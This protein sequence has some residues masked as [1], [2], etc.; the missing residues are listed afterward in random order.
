MWTVTG[1]EVYRR[2]AVQVLRTWAGMD[3][4]RYA[5]FPDAHIHTGHPLYQFL[6]AAEI[7]RATRPLADDTPGTYGGYDVVWSATDD[8]RLLTNFADPVVTTFLH[9]NTRWMNQ[10][11]FGLFGRLATAIYADD[12]AGYATGVE[13]FTV[14]SAYPG[15]DNGA[16]APQIPLLEVDD[17]DNPY[18]H[19]IVQVREMGRDQ[20]HGECNIDNFTGLA[21]ILEVQG[22]RVDPGAG[23]VSTRADAVSSY[24]F[25]GR[26]LL[27]G[28]NA[29][30][31]F[32]LGAWVPWADERGEGWDGTVSQAYRGRLFNPVNEL[33]YEYAPE[34][35]VDVATEAPWLARLS[36]RRDGPYF[37]NGTAVTNFWAPGDKNPEYWVA[38]PAELAGTAPPARPASADLPFARWGL[39][40]DDR[41]EIVDGVARAHVTPRGTTGVVTRVMHDGNGSN[42]LLVRADGAAT[43]EVLDKEPASPR[44]PDGG[45]RARPAAG[46]GWRRPPARCYGRRMYTR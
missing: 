7:I 30:Y 11:N 31:G 33:F 18:G 3:P 1:D 32:M 46:N 28:A 17:P 12:A 38:F 21:R 23:T 42:A 14:N 35:G 10:H 24:D 22:T 9:S 19:D 29:F 40:L 27:A 39:P 36:E 34:R 15:Y 20:A 13:W 16:L 41:T 8:R 26:R 6:M 2:N 25:L 5:Y 37:H 45:H 44:N 4:E 43:L